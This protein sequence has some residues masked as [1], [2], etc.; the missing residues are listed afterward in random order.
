MP[1][2]WE[3]KPADIAWYPP[4]TEEKKAKFGAFFQERAPPPLTLPKIPG[5]VDAANKHAPGGNAFTSWGIIGYCWGGK[6]ASLL[7]T[8]EY[9]GLFKAAVQCHPAMVDA[10]DAEKVVI[11]M[12]MLASKDEPADDVNAFRE[13]LKV[14]KFVETWS[15]QIHGWMS[16]RAD[17]A[18]EEVKKEYENGYKVALGFFNEHL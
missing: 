7:A 13:A 4:D 18:D 17:L 2:I 11:P 9:E 12:A 16:A 8:K 1:D 14:E 15:T 6:I 5:L 10:K 3:G